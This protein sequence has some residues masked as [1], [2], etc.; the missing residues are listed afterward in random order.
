MGSLDVF[1]PECDIDELSRPEH[2]TDDFEA[3]GINSKADVRAVFTDHP[4][5]I[6]DEDEASQPDRILRHI[7]YRG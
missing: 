1:R 6:I 4:G 3:A 7:R 2:V 5:W